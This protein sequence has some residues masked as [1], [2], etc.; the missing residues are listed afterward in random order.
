MKKGIILIVVI[1][2]A[3]VLTTLSLVSLSLMTQQGRVADH[4]IR[5]MRGFYAAQAGLVS[6]L[7]ELRRAG[8]INTNPVTIGAGVVGY[9]A[10]GLSVNITRTAGA[11][12]NSTDEINA[13]VNYPS[14]L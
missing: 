11:G 12:P 8:A 7:E 3:I 1:A 5:R 9:P 4:K 2:I 10:G 6:A 14:L 13:T